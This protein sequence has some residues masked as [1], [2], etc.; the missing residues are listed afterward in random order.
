MISKEKK[1]EGMFKKKQFLIKRYFNER[2]KEEINVIRRAF[3]VKLENIEIKK[4]N[5][6][7][8]IFTDIK[9]FAKLSDFNL[10]KLSKKELC[11]RSMKFKNS[12]KRTKR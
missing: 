6:Q 9:S 12:I 3:K 10:D 8:D 2:E 7:I 4:L 11:N 5:E 1:V